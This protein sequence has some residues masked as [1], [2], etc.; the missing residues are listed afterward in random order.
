MKPEAMDYIQYRLE[1]ARAALRDAKTLVDAGSLHPAVNRLYYACF[2]CVSALLLSEGKSFSKHSG[3]RAFFDR[4]FVKAGRVP[5]TLARF[6]RRIQDR[7]QKADYADFITFQPA[8]VAKWL[9]EA[10]E[11]VNTLSKLVQKPID[12]GRGTE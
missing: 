9:D 10:E 12:G 1:R 2:Y 8:E 5:V 7:R 6:Y 3:V 11:F 4:D